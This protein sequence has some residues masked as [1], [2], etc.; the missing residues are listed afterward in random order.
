MKTDSVES[1]QYSIRAVDRVCDILDIVR[2]Q[3]EGLSLSQISYA[4]DLPKSS[5]FRYLSILEERNYLQRNPETSFYELGFAFQSQASMV[6][7]QLKH[8]TEPLLRRLRD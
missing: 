1:R 3:R 7:V 5:V 8:I 2:S 4:A 6:L